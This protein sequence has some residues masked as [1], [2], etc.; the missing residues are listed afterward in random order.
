MRFSLISVRLNKGSLNSDFGCHPKC[1]VK[2]RLFREA[3]EETPCRG[4]PER[5]ED[6]M[7]Q[8]EERHACLSSE[9]GD[10]LDPR[11]LNS[12]ASQPTGPILQGSARD[13]QANEPVRREH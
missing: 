6:A 12:R 10:S 3:E 11:S 4:V 5:T 1:C 2:A 13:E 9:K 8:G 7:P